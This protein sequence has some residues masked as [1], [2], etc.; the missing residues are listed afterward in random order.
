MNKKI[1]ILAVALFATVVV[2]AQNFGVGTQTP[3]AKTHIVQENT[4]NALRVDD[5]TNDATPFVI[6]DTGNIE[7]GGNLETAGRIKDKTGYVMP[8]GTVVSYMGTTAPE[9]WLIC[10][11]SEIARDTYNDLFTVLGTASGYG[12]NVTTFNL[13]DMRG[14]FMR[15]MDNGT[16]NDPDAATRTAQSIG[17][18]TGDA[19]GSVQGEATSTPNNEFTTDIDGNHTHTT[20]IYSG[21]GGTG[22]GPDLA[23]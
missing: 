6:D 17:G 11:G 15:G 1:T 3:T 16:G 21:S 20:Y 9:G 18:N 5:E 10:D 13:P 19:V 23:A 7:T 2:K 12:N 8:V 4:E 22:V 14:M